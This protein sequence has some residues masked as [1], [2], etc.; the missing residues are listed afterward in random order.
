[1]LLQYLLQYLNL[2]N[3]Y[4]FNIEVNLLRYL[5]RHRHKLRKMIHFFLPVLLAATRSLGFLFAI[6]DK[7]LGCK[8]EK[9]C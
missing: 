9:Y 3:N 1:M 6:C 4:T 5:I 7:K 2:S 8:E